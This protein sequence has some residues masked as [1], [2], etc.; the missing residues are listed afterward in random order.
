MRGRYSLTDHVLTRLVGVLILAATLGPWIQ[1]SSL[2]P[3]TQIIET[4]ALSFGIGVAL[5]GAVEGVAHGIRI[6]VIPRGPED[7]PR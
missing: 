5:L 7:P 4:I 6:F 3:G 1:D 2:S